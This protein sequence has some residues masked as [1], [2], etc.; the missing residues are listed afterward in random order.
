MPAAIARAEVDASSS[1]MGRRYT[2]S[3]A[4]RGRL[5]RSS[6]VASVPSTGTHPTIELSAASVPAS[7]MPP[8]TFAGARRHLG[9][10]VAAP[11]AASV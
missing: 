7:S 9:E 10:T 8:L 6:I 2:S 11:P 3:R 5:G 1:G 4:V